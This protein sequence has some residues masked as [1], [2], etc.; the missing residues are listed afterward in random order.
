[1]VRPL[2]PNQVKH[3]SMPVKMTEKLYKK[4]LVQNFR[5]G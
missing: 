1:M 3:P 5:D 2:S 4:I